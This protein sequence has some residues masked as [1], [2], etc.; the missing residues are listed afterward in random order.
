MHFSSDQSLYQP[1]NGKSPDFHVTSYFPHRQHCPPPTDPV[2]LFNFGESPVPSQLLEGSKTMAFT[3]NDSKIGSAPSDL[4][5]LVSMHPQSTTERNTLDVQFSLVQFRMVSTRSKK[6]I[7]AQPRLSEVSL[8]PTSPSKR[9][10]KPSDLS[11]KI[12]NT[13]S[14]RKKEAKMGARWG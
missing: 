7:C 2:P 9:F 8:Q 3:S 1:T 12:P 11:Q 10:K 14:K 4:Y 6:P 5:E 13:A